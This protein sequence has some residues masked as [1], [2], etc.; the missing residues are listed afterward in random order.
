MKLKIATSC[1]VLT[2]FLCFG[3]LHGQDWLNVENVRDQDG[4]FDSD[5][6]Y[7]YPWEHNGSSVFVWPSAP[8][9]S[10]M[11]GE[12][13]AEL[14]LEGTN[15]DIR[16]SRLV[17]RGDWSGGGHIDDPMVEGFGIACGGGTS[18]DWT[19][20]YGN[21]ESFSFQFICDDLDEFHDPKDPKSGKPQLDIP[22]SYFDGD[23]VY[24]VNSVSARFYLVLS[25]D[26]NDDAEFNNGDIGA[27]VLALLDLEM[28]QK[29]YP[30][31]DVDI[32]LDMNH[33]GEFNNGDIGAFVDALLG[34]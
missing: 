15:F 4:T 32:R 19:D 12:A 34:N 22:V 24:H 29:M 27:F 25:G 9:V 18:W 33:D 13:I 3:H 5:Y 21:I 26:A 7:H 17:V 10:P 23:G 6:G 14:D 11:D 1:V 31:V 20:K 8:P 16:L 30:D 2:T 28:Y